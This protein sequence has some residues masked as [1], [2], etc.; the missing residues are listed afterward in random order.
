MQYFIDV[1]NYSV[2]KYGEE[3]CGD[4]VEHIKTQDGTITVLADGLGSG[5]K[6]NILA[7][8]TSK[9]AITMLK[10]GASIEETIDTITNTLPECSVRK[11]AYATFT[12]IK[13]DNDGSV[14][15]VEYDNPSVFF[16]R[17][18]EPYPIKKV[19]K[20]VNNKLIYESRFKMIE[21]DI[22][23]IVSDGVIHAGIGQK[24][25]LGWQWE[26]VNEYLSEL[27]KLESNAEK[28]AANLMSVCENLYANAL[29][30][31]TT[32]IT[33]ITRAK[34]YI[35]LFIGPPK[36]RQNDKL[37]L[38]NIK[39]AK[40]KV[41][42]CGGTTANIVSE[43]F[44]TP[45][46]IDLINYTSEV[47]PMGRM[48]GVELVTEGLLTLNKVKNLL[49]NYNEQK[50]QGTIPPPIE[51]LDG[52]STLARILIDQSTHIHLWVGRAVNPAHQNP[53]FPRTFNLK[54]KA[55]KEI[56][57]YLESIGKYVEIDYL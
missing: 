39:S 17:K 51:G 6:A 19:E 40:G 21:N 50:S 38:Q 8:L 52:A 44:K 22:L 15:M 53:N 45:I 24:L 14:Y 11:L 3:L 33:I 5:V 9:I 54:I 13:V 30:D 18:G 43:S 25:N 35:D 26:H 32:V 2:N 12:I 56:K 23:T 29:G 47:P 10:E 27:V 7:T 42:L 48:E 46:E 55:M 28:I 20:E 36:D 34:Q 49:S 31:D 4:N 41:I 57:N 37:L 1:A 16:Y